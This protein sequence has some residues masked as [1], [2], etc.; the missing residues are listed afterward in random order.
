MTVV[1]VR[2][3]DMLE[4]YQQ[5]VVQLAKA[6]TDPPEVERTITL[7]EGKTSEQWSFRREDPADVS[8]SYKVAAF[9]KDGAVIENDW[10][11]TDNPL[12]IV[13]DVAAGVLSVEV[14]FLGPLADG[15]QRLAKLELTYPDAPSWADPNVEQVFRTGDEE[16]TWRVP[17][18]RADA[19]SYTYEVTWF[20]T[21]GQRTTTGPVTTN[22]EILLLDPND[23]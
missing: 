16:F 5:V 1:D 9:L 2:L 6:G 23:P 10:V 22:D 8:F 14:M 3:A 17:M 18:A 7:G 4:R 11:T 20:G 13:G 21:D 19:T 12:V 15:G